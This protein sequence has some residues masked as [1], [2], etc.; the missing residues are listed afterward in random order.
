[1]S[2]QVEQPISPDRVVRDRRK[3]KKKVNEISNLSNLLINIFFWIY[4]GLCVIPL[5]LVVIVSFSDETDVLIKGYSFFPKS[6]DVAS[7]A[8]LL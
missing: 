6:L 4:T 8:F 2:I 1:M 5:L 7:Y 3:R